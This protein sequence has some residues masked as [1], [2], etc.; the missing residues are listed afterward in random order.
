[1]SRIYFD[2]NATTREEIDEAVAR[3]TIA[4]GI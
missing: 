4:I 3:V 2:F 1:M